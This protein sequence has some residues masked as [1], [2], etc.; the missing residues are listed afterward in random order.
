[1]GPR[2]VGLDNAVGENGAPATAAD[3]EAA[4][5]EWAKAFVDRC[6]S[7]GL[8]AVA[9]TDHHEMVMV[10]YIERAIQERKQADP[11]VDLWLFPGM[12][13]TASGGK[14]CLIIFDADLSE[15]WREQ[16]Q[17]KLGIAYTNLD[18]LSAAGPRVTQLTCPYPCI[19][20]GS[21]DT[22]LSHAAGLSDIA[23][24]HA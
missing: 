11:G 8:Q 15:S 2:P 3:V 9:L 20:P 6:V 24:C 7:R 1:M 17:G 14:Q 5:A 10:P 4:R 22:S 18:K 13:L 21:L 16:A 19:A 12:E 23:V